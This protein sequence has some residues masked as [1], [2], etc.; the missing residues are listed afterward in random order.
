MPS[1]SAADVTIL[2]VAC[3]AGMGSSAM[4]AS[5]IKKQLKKTDVE[6]QHVP[7]HHLPPDAQVVV[8]HNSLAAVAREK[9]PDAVVVSFQMFL[10]DPA[11]TKLVDTIKSG[12][13]VDG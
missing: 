7:V 4:L 12:G 6:V 5:T 11:V 3:D 10:G 1:I 13:V 2:Y 8:T 9:A